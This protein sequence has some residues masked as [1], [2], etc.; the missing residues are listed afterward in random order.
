MSLKVLIIEDETPLRHEL[1][2]AFVVEGFSVFEAENGS[3]GLNLAFRILPDIILLDINMPEMNGLEM[4]QELRNYKWGKSIPVIMLTNE[5]ANE[6][7]EQATL[8]GAVDYLVK[9]EWKSIDVAKKARQRLEK[10]K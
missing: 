1:M 9:T 4:L 8:Q 5:T 2:Q 3:L 6:A 7:M 10:I